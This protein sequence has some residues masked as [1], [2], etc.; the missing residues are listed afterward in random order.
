MS[1]DQRYLISHAE[2]HDNRLHIHWADG[3]DSEYHPVMLR[4]Q[5]ECDLCGTPL[6]AV[7]GLYIHQIPEDIA[8]EELSVETEGIGVTWQPWHESTYRA[9]WLRDHCNADDERRR[10]KHRPRL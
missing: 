9:K 10:R 5:C 4:H 6:N 7:R 3:H 1:D 2:V 8:I